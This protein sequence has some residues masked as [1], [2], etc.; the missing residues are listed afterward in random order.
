MSSPQQPSTSPPW[1]SLLSRRAW[2]LIG[3]AFTIGLLLFVLTWMAQRPDDGFFRAAAPATDSN[4]EAFKPLPTPDAAGADTGAPDAAI[5]PGQPPVDTVSRTPL[6]PPVER[7]PMPVPIPAPNVAT[8][9]GSSS[10]TPVHHPAPR[11]PPRALRNGDAGTVLLQVHVDMQGNPEQVDVV[12]SSRSRDL[13]REAKRTVEQ[14]RFKPA[15]RNGQA[16]ASKVLVP[17]DF[18]PQR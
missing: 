16:V 15:T 1:K 3:A 5:L 7:A 10:A 17:V 11:Y 12:Q 9:T 18:K 13:D 2:W 14:W 8:A 6:P 4:G